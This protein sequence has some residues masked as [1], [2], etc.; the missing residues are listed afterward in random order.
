MMY[1]ITTIKAIAECAEELIIQDALLI[2]EVKD[3][4]GNGDCILFG[5]TKDELISDE[6]VQDA[7]MNNTP[8]SDWT[9]DKNNVYHAY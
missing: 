6:D 1:E 2:H 7:L 3:E 4:F 8:I 5:Y 9:I